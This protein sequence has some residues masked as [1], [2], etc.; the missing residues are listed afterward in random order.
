MPASCSDGFED[1]ELGLRAARAG[2][3]SVCQPAA[4]ARHAG[5][6]TIGARSADRLYFA[7]RNHLRVAQLGAP[8]RPIA[9][10]ARSATILALNVA[11]ALFTARAPRLAGLRAVADGARDHW[12]GRYGPRSASGRSPLDG[13]GAD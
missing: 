2:F 10:A 1:L 13:E 11:H 5:A 6:R 9:S 12:R 8:L 7:T 3:R 4:V